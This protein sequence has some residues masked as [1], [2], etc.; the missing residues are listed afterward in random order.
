MQA[1]KSKK[2]R[3]WY[4]ESLEGMVRTSARGAT[5]KINKKVET[6]RSPKTQKDPRAEIVASV[7]IFAP[8]AVILRGIK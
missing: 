5:L 4:E 6:R 7:V 8:G 2:W 3:N 1:K